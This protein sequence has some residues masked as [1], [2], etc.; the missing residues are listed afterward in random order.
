MANKPDTLR[1]VV[2]ITAIPLALALAFLLISL[3]DGWAS[4]AAPPNHPSR[5]TSNWDIQTVDSTGSVGRYTSLALDGN[6]HPHI[7]YYD[8]DAHDLKYTKRNAP[9]PE[10]VLGA[11]LMVGVTIL[12]VL[13]IIH[14]KSR[15]EP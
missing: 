12:G 3:P 5:T 14:R 11:G 8:F 13:I 2:L 6:G 1:Y 9:V 4:Q 15:R 10:F 7:S